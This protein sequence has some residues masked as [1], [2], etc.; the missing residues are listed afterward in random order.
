[1]VVFDD[2]FVPN[3]RIFLNGEAKY[4]GRWSRISQPGIAPTTEAARE[5]TLTS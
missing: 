1:M 4:V 3:D 5:A 2:V